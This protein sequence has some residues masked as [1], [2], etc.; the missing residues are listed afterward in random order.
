MRSKHSGMDLIGVLDAELVIMMSMCSRTDGYFCNE[1]YR[2]HTA[3]I[4]Y[5]ASTRTVPEGGFRKDPRS[6]CRIPLSSRIHEC[7][8]VVD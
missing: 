2:D 6:G 1:V 5:A 8:P 4:N 3:D 7:H